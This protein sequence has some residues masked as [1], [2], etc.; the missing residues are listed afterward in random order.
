MVDYN[1]E[2]DSYDETRGGVPRAEA[3]AETL[4]A[5]LPGDVRHV[6]DVA[7]GTGLVAS[8][9]TRWGYDML[10]CDRSHGM[11]DVARTRV[12]GRAVA[13]DAA[14]LPLTDGSMDAAVIIWLLHLLPDAE[15]VIA[16]V[17][18]VVRPGGTFVTT[19]DK[20]SAYPHDDVEEILASVRPSAWVGEASDGRARIEELVARHGLRTC[21]EGRFVGHGQ[22]RAP[23]VAA[24]FVEDGRLRWTGEIQRARL[25]D[26]VARL[27]ALPD[28]ERSRTP[29]TYSL[30]AFT[31]D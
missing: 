20:R 12:P 19:V 24:R 5:I 14:N 17:S 31:K 6:V 4:A 9:L 22:G 26:A 25:A 28:P 8:R 13:G 15:P 10:V 2:A 29:P 27:R 16:E 3:A 1:R 30:L 21:G 7:G 11:L 18:R 23:E